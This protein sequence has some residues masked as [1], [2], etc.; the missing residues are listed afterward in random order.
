MTRNLRYIKRKKANQKRK[1]ERISFFRD[2]YRKLR[3]SVIFYGICG[4]WVGVNEKGHV[5]IRV[6]SIEEIDELYKS[7]K[8]MPKEYTIMSEHKN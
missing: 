3:D 6:L 8:P 4:T 2:I 7:G 5:E 1:M